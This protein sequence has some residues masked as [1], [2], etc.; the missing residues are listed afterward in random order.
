[1]EIR[2]ASDRSLLVS[3]GSEIS[4]EAH[5]QVRA[6][7]EHLQAAPAVLNLHP[8]YASVLIDFD[9]RR[10]SH[11]DIEELVRARMS[12]A[13]EK[14]EQEARILEIQVSYGG[15]AGPDLEDVARHT[16]LTA[17]R[18]V[19][20][21]SSALYL[22]Y[23]LGFSPGF[24]YLGGLPPALATPRLSAPRKRVPAGSIAIGGSQAGI[25]PVESPGGW[26]IIGSTSLR[27]FDP[28]ADPPARL[29]IGDHVRFV[30]V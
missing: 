2:P 13:L 18:V 22:V 6:L 26:R 8:A 23:F 30:P 16:G 11:R 21:H 28:G 1:M 17:S 24:P 14:T 19:E 9:P 27:L 3:F 15:S 29:G 20:L 25:Y 5:R 10:R 4:L 12:L 7:V